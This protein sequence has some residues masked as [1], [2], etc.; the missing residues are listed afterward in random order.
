M[1]ARAI[2]ANLPFSFV[3]ANSVYSTGDIETTLRKAGKGY[4]LGVAANRAFNSWSETLRVGGSAETIAQSLPKKAWRRLSAGEGTKGARLY[5]WA[6][7]EL[8]DLDINEYN[9]SPPDFGP[10]DC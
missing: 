5:D 3:A 7:L 6:H 10:E 2:G 4:V 9:T 8:A 1:I